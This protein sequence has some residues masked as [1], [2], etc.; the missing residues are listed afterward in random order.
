MNIDLIKRIDIREE[1]PIKSFSIAAFICKKEN[2]IGNYLILKRCSK[3]LENSWQMVSG[4]LEKGE[5]AWEAALREI[6][7]ETG[8]I[9]DRLYSA[10]RIESFYE[11][12]QNCINLVPVFIGFIDHDVEVKLSNFEQDDYK[13]VTVENM[14]DYLVFS[15][16][17][18]LI[19]YFEENFIQ[20]SP[21]EFL[22]VQFEK[23]DI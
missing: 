21:N 1:V 22:R 4:R 5:T 10:N 15:N 12:N 8:I 6:K 2:G 19:Q 3:Y 23:N 9:P 13:W 16:Q 7:E 20:N 18:E 14:S 17:I 11:V